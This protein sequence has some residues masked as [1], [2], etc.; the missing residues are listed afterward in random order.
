MIYA[1]QF[2]A[3]AKLQANNKYALCKGELGYL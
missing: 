2:F 1:T 3:Q